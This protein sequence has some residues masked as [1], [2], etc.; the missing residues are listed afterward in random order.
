M[1]PRKT[2]YDPR[3]VW[4]PTLD[5]GGYLFEDCVFL[6]FPHVVVEVGAVEGLFEKDAV[7]DVESVNY[8]F[9]DGFVGCGC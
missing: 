4:V 2:I 9:D 6:L 5:E 8:V 3:L 1:G 7:G